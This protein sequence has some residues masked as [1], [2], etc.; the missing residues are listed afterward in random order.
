MVRCD[1]L[2]TPDATVEI[3]EAFRRVF[4][5][6]S[7]RLSNSARTIDTDFALHVTFTIQNYLKS[8]NGQWPELE[9]EILPVTSE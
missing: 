7:S 4:P 8:I 5:T 3:F 1:I 9:S 2:W 6:A